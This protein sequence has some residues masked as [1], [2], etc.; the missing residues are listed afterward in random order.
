M[1]CPAT[2][3][4]RGE[5]AQCL[6]VGGSVVEGLSYDGAS[7]V[8]GGPGVALG[9]TSL[10]GRDYFA[11]AGGP[12]L[13]FNLVYR[14]EVIPL[15]SVEDPNESRGETVYR[16]GIAGANEIEDVLVFDEQAP[17]PRH[18]GPAPAPAY[19]FGRLLAARA[20]RRVRGGSTRP[21]LRLPSRQSA[22]L[23]LATMDS[24]SRNSVTTPGIPPTARRGI[25]KV[26]PADHPH[27]AMLPRILLL[28]TNGCQEIY[29]SIV[30][31]HD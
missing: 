20:I 14:A 18:L 4:R 19:S 11:E 6:E 29:C 7:S 12:A 15:Y 5:D 1:P 30:Q 16:V 2:T 22:P 9:Q 13:P 25:V 3:D 17:I 23:A 24:V 31:I 26:Q 28:G 27:E 10:D 8:S 21:I